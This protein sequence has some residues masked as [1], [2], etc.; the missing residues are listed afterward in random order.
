M[1]FSPS[2]GSSLSQSVKI[3]AGTE[4]GT[5]SDENEE[6]IIFST[7]EDYSFEPPRL[8]WFLTR[9]NANKDDWD[10]DASELLRKEGGLIT[11][12]SP[13]GTDGGVAAFALGFENDLSRHQ[14]AITFTQKNPSSSLVNSLSVSWKM[15]CRLGEPGDNKQNWENLPQN[16]LSVSPQTQ[17]QRISLE[18]PAGCT[19]ATFKGRT[20]KTW[21]QGVPSAGSAT[22]KW[23]VQIKVETTGITLPVTQSRL[24]TDEFELIGISNGQPGQSFK[25]RS[26]PFL[27]PLDR[28]RFVQVEKAPRTDDWGEP[29]MIVDDFADSE[30]TDNRG[31]E[32]RKHCVLDLREATVTFGPRFNDHQFG[33]IPP[34]ESR[35]RVGKY[36][37]GGGKRGNLPAGSK[38]SLLTTIPHVSP[39]VN[40]IKGMDG[41]RDAETLEAARILAPGRVRRLTRERAVTAKDFEDLLGEMDGV[42]AVYCVRQEDVT[43]ED[44]KE[45]KDRDFEAGKVKLLV[46]PALPKLDLNDPK[47][48]EYTQQFLDLREKNHTVTKDSINLFS[49]ELRLSNDLLGRLETKLHESSPLTATIDILEPVYTWIQVSVRIKPRS[50]VKAEQEQVKRDLELAL[51]RYFHPVHGGEDNRGWAFRESVISIDRIYKVVGQFEGIKS[52]ADAVLSVVNKDSE[53]DSMPVVSLHRRSV[54]H[55]TWHSVAFLP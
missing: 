23:E 37:V 42:G 19:E 12:W 30:M 11:A 3:S 53:L 1:T 25:L 2:T 17:T 13:G 9:K 38:L 8:Q 54:V 36:R 39:D 45:M 5:T 14:L 10:G 32:N 41:G 15:Y 51:Y 35:I 48:R 43:E 21:I 20:A 4:I 55:S 49:E 52:A 29:W 50:G 26:S 46:I 22:E 31:N 24:T 6:R 28:E 33:E 7:E 34:S 40:C 27:A 47:H 44:D 18:L 16:P